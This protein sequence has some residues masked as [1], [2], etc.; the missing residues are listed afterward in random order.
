MLYKGAM[1]Q[2]YNPPSDN[3]RETHFQVVTGLWVAISCALLLSATNVGLLIWIGVNTKTTQ[4]SVVELQDHVR[5]SMFSHL[6]NDIPATKKDDLKTKLTG[7]LETTLPST[8]AG[9]RLETRAEKLEALVLLEKK[10]PLFVTV[11]QPTQLG[12][13]DANTLAN[14]LGVPDYDFIYRTNYDNSLQTQN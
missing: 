14:N 1:P 4:E 6:V 3:R 9:R 5:V 7:I 13:T 11:V 10:A 8:N 2:S 12:A